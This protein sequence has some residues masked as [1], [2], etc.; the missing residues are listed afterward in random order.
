[1]TLDHTSTNRVYGL[2]TFLKGQQEET[3]FKK[4]KLLS[5]HGDIHTSSEERQAD[6]CAF[7]ARLEVQ[8]NNGYIERPCLKR[9]WE[10]TDSLHPLKD[11]KIDRNFLKEVERGCIG[12]EYD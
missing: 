9:V 11:M 2:L 1:M 12:G 8:D 4:E 5:R 10:G 7:E 6:F 3:I